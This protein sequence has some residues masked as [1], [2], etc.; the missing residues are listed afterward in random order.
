MDK[1]DGW[2]K[3]VLDAEISGLIT[4]DE[5]FPLRRW[6]SKTALCKCGCPLHV[7]TI[8]MG[9]ILLSSIFKECHKVLKCGCNIKFYNQLHNYSS[10]P[11]VFGLIEYCGW[12]MF[13]SRMFLTYCS[14]DDIAMP[15]CLKAS[16]HQLEI[17][18]SLF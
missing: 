18:T 13:Y 14:S 15:L 16:L 12:V 9:R 17:R 5:H 8:N 4:S 3:C 10:L 2:L 7:S 6:M 11:V 1:Y